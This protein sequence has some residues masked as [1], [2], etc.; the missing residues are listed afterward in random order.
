MVVIY[1]ISVGKETD[2]EMHFQKPS[3]LEKKE[4]EKIH[5]LK[6]SIQQIVDG[7]DGKLS[8]NADIIPA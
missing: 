7:L 4:L 1:W 5:D 2:F 6:K 3:S 8:K